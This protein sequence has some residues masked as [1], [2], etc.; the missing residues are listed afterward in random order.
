MMFDNMSLNRLP[1][2]MLKTWSVTLGTNP[3]SVVEK[4]L[5]MPAPTS[6]AGPNQF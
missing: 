3:M 5:R 4:C 1:D 2:A 6:K